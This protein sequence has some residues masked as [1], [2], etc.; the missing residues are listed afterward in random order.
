MQ[1]LDDAG[2]RSPDNER[3]RVTRAASSQSG[4]AGYHHSGPGTGTGYRTD[5]ASTA[6]SR[7]RIG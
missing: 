7:L 6:S 3:L 5:T 4:A 1:V 2:H